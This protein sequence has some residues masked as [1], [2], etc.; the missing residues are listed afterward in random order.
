[1]AV[2]I[3]ICGITNLDDA[4]L[5]A[6]L[7]ADAL[8]FIFYDKSPRFITPAAAREIIRKL[9]PFISTVGVFVNESAAVIR[10]IMEDCRLDVLQFHGDEPG[11][12]TEINPGRRIKAIQIKDV[13]SLECIRNYPAG[14]AFVLDAYHPDKFGG[15]GLSFDWSLVREFLD[16]YRIILAGGLSAQNVSRAVE[17]IKPYGVDVASGVEAKP[18]HKDPDKLRKFIAAVRTAC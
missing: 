11:G 4:L 9:P 10:R 13:S 18:G 12:L 6:K 15:T 16:D 14:S 3:K 1:M 8:G 5:A 17:T 7:G 2:R